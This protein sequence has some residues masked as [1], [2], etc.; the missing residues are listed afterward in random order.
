[1]RLCAQLL[2]PAA[3]AWA[4]VAPGPAMAA[5]GY[6]DQF[7][8]AGSGP[9][10][11][12]APKGVAVAADGTIFVADTGNHRIQVFDA[13]GNFLRQWG[14]LG[15]GNGQFNGP[16]DLTLGLGGVA[17]ADTG[18]DRLLRFDPFGATIGCINCSGFSNPSGITF[19]PDIAFYFIANTDGHEIVFTDA[20]VM[21]SSFGEIGISDGQ[22]AA[23]QGVT[24]GPSG[25]VYVA[26]TNIDRIQRFEG[27]HVGMSH[28]STF[29]GGQVDGPHDIASDAG[30]TLY[31]ADTFNNRIQ[32]FS[33]AGALIGPLGGPGPG[34][35][36]FSQPAGVDADCHGNVYV[37][38][39]GN[40][41]IQ[42]LGEPGNSKPPCLDPGPGPEPGPA[43]SPAPGPGAAPGEGFASF[44]VGAETLAP[45]L[46]ILG[47]RLTLN[48]RGLL[49]ARLRCPA[50]GRSGP[51]RGTLILKTQPR[52]P[53]GGKRRRVALARTS[54][55]VPAGKTRALSMQFGTRQVSLV[56]TNR[57]ARRIEAIAIVRGRAGERLRLAKKMRLVV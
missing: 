44:P 55:S 18:N 17:V 26:D 50:S 22:F 45:G 7:G 36:Q 57:R 12:N 29:G 11:F 9:G 31:V 16:R 53:F 25:D 32:R 24:A 39:T 27:S 28:V 23:P 52:L 56:R 38:D 30:G 5:L 4:L 20:S 51:C 47:R 42:K 49:R 41:R 54:F 34:P 43:P 8:T 1:M 2:L 48:R 40:D 14:S 37:A 21:K 15:V 19:R 6:L 13:N 35:G 46:R 33:A 3:L 10:Q